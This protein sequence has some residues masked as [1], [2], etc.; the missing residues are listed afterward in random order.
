MNPSPPP[1]D[2]RSRHDRLAGIPRFTA[3][4]GRSGNSSGWF[5]PSSAPGID[6]WFAAVFPKK[7]NNNTMLFSSDYYNGVFAFSSNHP[8]L[9]EGVASPLPP[10]EQQLSQQQQQ[11]QEN[12]AKFR[13]K[14]REE[15]PPCSTCRY[16]GMAVCAGLSLYFLRLAT[17]ETTV[18]TAKTTAKAKAMAKN[19]SKKSHKAFFYG[20]ALVWAAAG[21]YRSMLD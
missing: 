5:P 3:M 12:M 10:R 6:A 2:P 15:E 8:S 18:T 9:C 17:E 13:R 4:S 16:T 11:H 1:P 20:G 19:A 14:L 7:N 21:V